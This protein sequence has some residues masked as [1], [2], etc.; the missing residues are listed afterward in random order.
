MELYDVLSV[1][2]YV[3]SI[4]TNRKL[5]GYVN[6]HKREKQKTDKEKEKEMEN[7]AERRRNKS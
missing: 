2:Q 3:P 4:L 6:C 7:I 5:S 1:S